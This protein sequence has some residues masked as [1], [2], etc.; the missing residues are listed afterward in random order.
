[1]AR[2]GMTVPEIASVSGHSLANVHQ[3]LDRHYFARDP[4]PSR[5]G[6]ERMENIYWKDRKENENN[7]PA[8]NRQTNLTRNKR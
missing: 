8:P 1:M 4:E 2:S 7:K 5:A 6:I 3:V